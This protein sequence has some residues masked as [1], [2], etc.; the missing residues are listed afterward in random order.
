MAAL[1][2][3]KA[4]RQ[5]M[6][7]LLDSDEYTV[8]QVVDQAFTI[9]FEEYEA[10]QK[11]VVVGQGYT[12]AGRRL[13]QPIKVALPP[14]ATEAPALDAARSLASEARSGVSMRVGV[15][16]VF[17]GSAFAFH[18]KMKDELAPVHPR[19]SGQIRQIIERQQALA[20]R[21]CRATTINARHEVVECRHLRGHGCPHGLW[22]PDVGAVFRSATAL[23][24]QDAIA[25]GNEPADG[26][27]PAYL[28]S[29][30]FG[31]S[32]W[33]FKAEGHDGDHECVP[34]V[35]NMGEWRL[36]S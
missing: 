8:D 23:T 1:K 20:D 24:E 36:P 15:M 26:R 33:C 7:D 28:W 21:W 6:M 16:P 22:S 31:Y 3:R 27:C 11:F 34:L 10:R 18:G 29:Q 32:V 14:F 2:P 17:H 35:K 4:A 25:L 19:E 30:Q 12:Q 9:A 13:E 5:A